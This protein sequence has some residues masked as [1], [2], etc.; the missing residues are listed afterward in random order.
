MSASFALSSP[1]KCDVP[2]PKQQGQASLA[3]S[4]TASIRG[5]CAWQ[6][7]AIAVFLAH[8]GKRLTR[9]PDIGGSSVVVCWPLIVQCLLSP[10]SCARMV[11]PSMSLG[12]SVRPQATHARTPDG[13]PIF[14]ADNGRVYRSPDRSGCTFNA[15]K[16]SVRTCGQQ[17]LPQCIALLICWF[18]TAMLR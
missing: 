13:G 7:A 16:A 14:R 12:M 4:V 17:G 18:H 2:P 11:R 6:H 3:P 8:C 10:S 15:R 5:S 9:F 1:T